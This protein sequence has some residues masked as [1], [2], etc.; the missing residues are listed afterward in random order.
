MSAVAT[1]M[2]PYAFAN[3][4]TKMLKNAGFDKVIRPQM[5]YNYRKNNLLKKPLTTEYAQEWVTRYI[6]RNLSA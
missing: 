3:E 5:M 6:K 1:E 2:S 4:V